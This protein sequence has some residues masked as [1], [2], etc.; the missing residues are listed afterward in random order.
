MCLGR[1]KGKVADR[2]PAVG[3]GGV[4]S[5]GTQFCKKYHAFNKCPPSSFRRGKHVRR[6]VFLLDSFS[7][8]FLSGA[9]G[10]ES[11]VRASRSSTRAAV[12]HVAQPDRQVASSL[13]PIQVGHRSRPLQD[14]N[15]E[16]LARAPTMAGPGFGPRDV[17]VE[18][19]TKLG[20]R[21]FQDPGYLVGGPDL[22][23]P[24]LDHLC[25]AF[26][27]ARSHHLHASR[28]S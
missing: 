1:E 3:V 25:A 26:S 17:H 8:S 18:P 15:N 14:V 23:L 4:S 2:P 28:L 19:A 5:A 10:R 13:T 20:P 9:P 21:H 7:D 16:D 11:F 12:R 27:L 22:P 6:T 24:F